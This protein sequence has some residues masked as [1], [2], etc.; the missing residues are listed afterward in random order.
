MEKSRMENIEMFLIT[1]LAGEKVLSRDG[2]DMCFETS[3]IKKYLDYVKENDP[4]IFGEKEALLGL[5]V[6]LERY[7]IPVREWEMPD[8]FSTVLKEM[9]VSYLDETLKRDREVALVFLNLIDPMAESMEKDFRANCEIAGLCYELPH[10]LL[11]EKEVF[12]ILLAKLG[13]LGIYREFLTEEEQLDDGI[14]YRLLEW[15]YHKHRNC[16]PDSKKMLL[17]NLGQLQGLWEKAVVDACWKYD[18]EEDAYEHQKLLFKAAVKER[19]SLFEPAVQIGGASES[20]DK[21]CSEEG[22]LRAP[23]RE[24]EEL[25][26]F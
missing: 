4:E 10:E 17:E 6:R 25:L 20:G 24:G 3:A 7:R 22:F 1:L 23:G 9:F 19:L 16:G 5:I 13:P 21:D 15:Y 18:L 14:L 26:P 2:W 8:L 11:L 12:G